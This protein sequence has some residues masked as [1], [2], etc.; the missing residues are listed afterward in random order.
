MFVLLINLLLCKKKRE[1]VEDLGDLE[2][3]FEDIEL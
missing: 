3:I 1:V 2:G